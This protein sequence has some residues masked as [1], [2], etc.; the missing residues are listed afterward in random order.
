M[1]GAACGALI[2]LLAEAAFRLYWFDLP[3]SLL[4]WQCSPHSAY[5]VDVLDP[6]PDPVIGFRFRPGLQRYFQCKRFSIN[7][8]S[9]RGRSVTVEKPPGT[10]RI[11]VLG[12]STELGYGV[13]DDESWPAQLEVAL[14][15]RGGARY[16]VLNVGFM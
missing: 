10:V 9:L 3:E 12:R 6:D 15:E 16:E 14:N 11:A 5:D 4:P 2:V 8:H 7:E 1:R 13:H